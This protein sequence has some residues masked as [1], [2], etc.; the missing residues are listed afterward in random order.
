MTKTDKERRKDEI[1]NFVK[2]K[3]EQT[4]AASKDVTPGKKPSTKIPP[5]LNATSGKSKKDKRRENEAKRDDVDTTSEGDIRKKS[6][7]EV[8]EA[9]KPKKKAK[10][11]NMLSVS[12]VAQELGLDPKRARAKLRASGQA[13]TEG[14]WA[15]VKRDS[16]EH[17]ALVAILKPKVDKGAAS[18]DDEESEGDESDAEGDEEDDDEADDEDDE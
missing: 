4:S 5:E 7:K 11:P 16:A 2:R 17:R 1:D 8:D 15:L 9:V 18:K 3:K 10:D 6:D 12:Q 14:R 13:A